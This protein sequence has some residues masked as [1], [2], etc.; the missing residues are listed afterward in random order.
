MLSWTP[1]HIFLTGVASVAGG[2]QC[3]GPIYTWRSQNNT[4]LSEDEHQHYLNIAMVK[5]K[6]TTI[7]ENTTWK[8]EYMWQNCWICSPMFINS[9]IID[10]SWFY[11]SCRGDVSINFDIHCETKWLLW[12]TVIGWT[13]LVR[14]RFYQCW[15]SQ[16]LKE[17]VVFTWRLMR[18]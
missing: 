13:V 8:W 11:L 17:R 9:V 7:W 18:R 6:N 14:H 4:C 5:L 12:D 10:L 15:Y 2:R 3:I 16:L 1:P